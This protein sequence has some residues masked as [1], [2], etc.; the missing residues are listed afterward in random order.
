MNNKALIKEFFAITFADFLVACAVYFFML[1]SHLTIGSVT[2]L[3]MVFQNLIPLNVS[4]ITFIVDA[5]LLAFAFIT[6]GKDFGFKTVYTSLLMP[7]FLGIFERLVPNVESI[8]QDQFVDMVMY[9]FIAGVGLAILFNHNASS[10]GLDIVAMFL[11]RFFHV[12]MGLANSIP[13][14]I[15]ALSAIFIYDIPTLL[16]SVLGTYIGGVVIDHFAFGLYEKKRICIISDKEEEIRH[17]ILD[18]LHCGATV[19]KAFGAYSGEQK[20]E[21]CL[22][23]NKNEYRKLMDYIKKIDPKAF[24]TVISIKELKENP[25]PKE[26]K[27]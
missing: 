26:N 12:D 4:T 2:A 25:I 21:L 10:G 19:Y 9:V 3:A 16:I 7:V 1:P 22:V 17:Y 8:M 18:V 24:V 23:V 27:K 15:V 6:I 14:M 5:A 11:N 20:N 13:G